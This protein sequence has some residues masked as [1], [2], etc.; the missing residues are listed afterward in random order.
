[1]KN[2]L[3]S[4]TV[5]GLLAAAIPG[6]GPAISAAV[7]SIP[8]ETPVVEAVATA[9]PIVSSEIDILVQ[10][11]GILFALYGRWKATGELSFK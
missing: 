7:L 8:S 6:V 4:K 5:W 1:M 9:G 11:V 3:K 2:P 10:A